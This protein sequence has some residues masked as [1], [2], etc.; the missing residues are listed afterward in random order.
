MTL[1]L[2]VT[3]VWTLLAVAAALGLSMLMQGAQRVQKQYLAAPRGTATVP[4]AR[5]GGEN[6]AAAGEPARLTHV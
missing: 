5:S 4:A 6:D 3:L 2:Q 1:V